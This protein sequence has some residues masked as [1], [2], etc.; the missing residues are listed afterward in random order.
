MNTIEGIHTEKTCSIQRQIENYE[1]SLLLIQERKSEF[2]ESERIPLDLI[3]NER[4]TEKKLAKLSEEL[5]QSQAQSKFPLRNNSK[6]IPKFLCYSLDCTK[7]LNMFDWKWID[8][9]QKYRPKLFLVY[10]DEYQALD[11]FAERL[12]E[13][14]KKKFK[15]VAVFFKRLDFE[16]RLASENK[17]Q[18]HLRTNLAKVIESSPKALWEKLNSLEG[19]VIIYTFIAT[20]QWQQC[21]DTERDISSYIRFWQSFPDF[22]NNPNVCVL[23]GIKYIYCEEKD[24]N[25]MVKFLKRFHRTNKLAVTNESIEQY[26]QV[27]SFSDYRNI[28]LK[29]LPKIDGV[30]R[31][32]AENWADQSEVK[33]YCSREDLIREI[34]E[35]FKSWQREQSS[36]LIPIEHLAEKFKS[37]LSRY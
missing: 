8:S 33:K 6:Q 22:V 34:R 10:G 28:D 31:G 37:I 7:Q 2:G 27:E 26:L 18:E 16:Y 15:D 24:S 5:E 13:K 20:D 30:T 4:A 1:G 36:N 12:K 35:I 32:D 9:S 21:A 29:I 14:C 19:P 11:I 23:L 3:K 25:P 17:I